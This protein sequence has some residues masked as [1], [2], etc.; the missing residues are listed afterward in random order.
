[1]RLGPD[2]VGLR[3]FLLLVTTGLVG[4]GLAVYGYGR[5]VVVVAGQG[6]V[7]SLSAAAGSGTHTQ[8]STTSQSTS[9]S[10]TPRSA[11]PAP[12]SQ[13]LGPLLSSSQYAPYAFRVYPG[14]ESSQAQTATAGFTIQV[15]PRAGRLELSV[16]VPG[17][18]QAG[19]TST[20]AA[21]DRVYFIEATLGDDSGN[22]EYNFGDDGVIVTNAK[23]YI[24]Q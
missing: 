22:S 14:P 18:G 15:A 20:L 11:S 2:R 3:G 4:I 9:P 8:A 10:P 16:S 6:G 5:G 23:G 7:T 19:Q 12:P 1:M 24:V 17:S 13:K 21:G